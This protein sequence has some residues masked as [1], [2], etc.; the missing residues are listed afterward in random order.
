MSYLCISTIILVTISIYRR[1]FIGNRA[2]QRYSNKNLVILIFNSLILVPVLEE[3]IFRF[4]IASFVNQ[5]LVSVIFT[6]VHITN[7]PVKYLDL[8]NISMLIAIYFM[9]EYLNTVS[10]YKGITIHSAFNT[11]TILF[12]L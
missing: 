10:I 11:I 6:L 5:K 9:A 1:F 2:Y 12:N 7:L 3:L 8:S 4:C